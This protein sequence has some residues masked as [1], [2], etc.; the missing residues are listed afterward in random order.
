MKKLLLLLFISYSSSQAAVEYAPITGS[1]STLRQLGLIALSYQKNSAR[2]E[3]LRE[4]TTLMSLNGLF[5]VIAESPK[6]VTIIDIYH[7][8][9]RTPLNIA[10]ADSE[11]MKFK[12]NLQNV[13]HHF[14]NE[15]GVRKRKTFSTED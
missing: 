3:V 7:A 13:V 14:I 1:F 4:N 12:K 5:E 11:H 6:K 10:K 2:I 15:Q 8:T 9:K